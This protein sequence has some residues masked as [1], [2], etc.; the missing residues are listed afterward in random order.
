MATLELSEGVTVPCCPPLGNDCPCD[1]LD[2]HYRQLHR[3]LV[4]VNDQRRPVVVEVTI[5]GTAGI[6]AAAV[7]VPPLDPLPIAVQ[8]QALR[9]V[10]ED[11]LKAGLLDAVGGV[12]SPEVQ[13]KLSFERCSSLP[14]PGLLVKGCF[15]ECD[16]CE[17]ELKRKIDLELQKMDLE[18]KC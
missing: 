18:I 15:D 9:Q 14:T 10:D 1:R 11:L 5:L 6:V 7:L 13:E 3:T 4:T 17:P 2:F 16:I 8:E 12:I